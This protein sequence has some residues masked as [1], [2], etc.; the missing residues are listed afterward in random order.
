MTPALTL[1]SPEKGAEDCLDHDELAQADE[2]PKL[3]K[4]YRASKALADI[5]NKDLDSGSLTLNTKVQVPR[6]RLDQMTAK[7]IASGR[8]QLS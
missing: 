2:M 7:G 4:K 5:S 3:Q 6:L 8:H 1:P